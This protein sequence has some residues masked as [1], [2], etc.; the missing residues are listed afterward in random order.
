MLYA[1]AMN[2]LAK[3]I[4]IILPSKLKEY[5]NGKVKETILLLQPNLSISSTSFGKT[6]SLLAV[7][8][9]MAIGFEILLSKTI[10]RFLRM[11]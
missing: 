8:K 6:A 10:I 2:I 1:C 11:R 9:A 7:L 5:P 3:V 4:Y